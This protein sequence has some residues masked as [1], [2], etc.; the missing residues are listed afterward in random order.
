MARSD[1]FELLQPT[2]REEWHAWLA[3]NHGSSP[4]LW[5]AIGKKGGTATNVTYG[6]AVEEAVAFGW[7][8]SKAVS[9]DAHRFRQLFTP[10]KRGSGWSRSNKARVS[11]L[12][13]EGRMQP[14]GLAAVETAKADGSWTR[15]DDVEDLVVPDDLDAALEI[16]GPAARA[17]FDG[18]SAS[19]RKAFLFWIADARRPETRARRVAETARLAELGLTLD[20]RAAQR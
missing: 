15:L 16:A 3:G 20:K 19:A 7:I 9:L 1:E 17:G 11:R 13:E 14:A 10:R 8:D 18:F 2:N 4:G 12:L 6:E 5:L